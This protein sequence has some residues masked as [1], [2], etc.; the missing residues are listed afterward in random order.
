MTLRSIG[1][2]MT[3]AALLI[4][5]SGAPAQDDPFPPAPP[6]SI[7]MSAESLV[8]LDA[9][10]RGYVERDEVVGAELHVIKNRRTVWH[11]AHGWRDREAGA[12]LEPGAIYCI[13]SMTKPVA[14]AAIQILIDE[15]RVRPGDLVRAYIPSFDHDAHRE[16]TVEHLL[17]HS[18]GLPLS[19]LLGTDFRALR[20][21]RDVADL[22]AAAELKFPPGT[23][24]NY[25]DDNADTLA[26]IVERVTG[27]PAELFIR[28]RL[29]DPLLMADASPVLGPDDPGRARV[30]C[31]YVGAAGSWV[32]GWSPDDGQPLFPCFLGSQ[33]MHATTTDYARFMAMWI[34]GGV[35][36][37]RRILS[38][39][40]VRRALTVARREAF[41]TGFGG[42]NSS[43]GQMWSLWVPREA[44]GAP[45]NAGR[46]VAFGHGGSDGTFAWAWPDLDLMILYFTSSR[47]DTTAISLEHQIDRLLFGA[48]P[49]TPVAPTDLDGLAGLYWSEEAGTCRAITVE[50]DRLM[51]EFPGRFVGRLVE[52]EAGRW[53]LELDSRV[54][55]TFEREGA[56]PAQAA[57]L[58][59]A[60][61]DVRWPRLEPDSTLPAIG[62]VVARVREAHGTAHVSAL[63]AIRRTA[64][65]A[66][67]PSSVE[68]K[69]TALYRGLG[70]RTRIEAAGRTV[71]HAVSD[72]RRAWSIDAG[73]A[74]SELTGAA[75]EQTVLDHPAVHFGDWRC[76]F[77]EVRVLARSRSDAG[78][79]LVVR[80]VPRH[81]R[82]F[83]FHVAESTGCV[84]KIEQM[85]VVPGLGAVGVVQTLDD[86]RDAGG[87]LLPHRVSARYASPLLGTMEFI[88]DET[89]T[90]VPT[91]DEDFAPR[92]P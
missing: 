75:A 35:A 92:G 55:L 78:P 22:A 43:Y 19:S 63:G 86:F 69:F 16:I 77:T 79:R 57:V 38:Q 41:P 26:A 11:T 2:V 54:T 12:S 44:A 21:V 14:G 20:G 51:I 60:D 74:A 52:G 33:S 39:D 45:G 46:V 5:P 50:G 49:A 1:S 56:G 48:A 83:V 84:V 9:V 32:R 70:S 28:Q 81:A 7:G 73:G 58:H 85:E 59:R 25:S 10:V 18:S 87:L 72:G 65:A 17:T 34:D 89:E 66:G 31:M 23:G 61:R 36:G 27:Q 91:R 37:D 64:T 42:L 80:A 90:G 15:G 68:M 13:R 29:L 82:P 4:A 3:M 62:E 76:Y 40:A 67:G 30:A 71:H 6:E 8:A 24:Y 53:R 47:N 88:F